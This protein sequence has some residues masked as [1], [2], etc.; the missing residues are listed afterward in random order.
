MSEISERCLVCL[1]ILDEEDLFCPN[2][3]REAPNRIQIVG[4]ESSSTTYSFDCK[5][6][7]ASMSYDA[8]VETLRCPFCGSHDFSARQES[9]ALTAHRVVPFQIGREQAEQILRHWLGRG[10]WRPNDLAHQAVVSDLA[11]VFVPY[12]VF[13]AKT[14]T[15]WTADSSQTPPGARG[16]WFPLTGEHRGEYSNVLIGGSS[17]LTPAE[18]AAIRPFNM[19][20]AAPPKEALSAAAFAVV[21]QFRVQRKFARPQA[22]QGLEDAERRACTVY[23]PGSARNVKVNVMVEGLAG[24]PVLLPVW[25]M[26]YRYRDQVFRFL[27]NGQ[28]GLAT[29][30]APISRLKVAAAI[31]IGGGLLLL[32]LIVLMLIGASR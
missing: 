27:L 6:C 31:A 25:I 15:Y 29:G 12:W 4:G 32:L 30:N 24:E 2:C 9:R 18:T 26:A 14:H 5:S 11:A 23:V 20:L 1:A 19:E 22:Q 13:S 7:G 28:T 8:A 16:D 21:E 10:F 17:V 3:G